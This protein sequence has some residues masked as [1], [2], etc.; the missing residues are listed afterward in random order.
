M[1]L[2]SEP[3]KVG[4]ISYHNQDL[5]WAAGGCCA[6]RATGRLWGA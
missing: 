6:G 3:D 2:N 4:Y 1:L 5:D